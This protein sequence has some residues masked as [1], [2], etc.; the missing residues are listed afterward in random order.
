[1]K[2]VQN[3]NQKSDLLAAWRACRPVCRCGP[4]VASCLGKY[5]LCPTCGELKSR[6]CGVAKCKAAAATAA[7]AEGT[8]VDDDDDSMTDFTN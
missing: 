3:E 6:Q 5:V 4:N 7:A 2:T 1:M 8:D